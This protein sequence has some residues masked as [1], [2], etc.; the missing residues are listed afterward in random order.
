MGLVITGKPVSPALCGQWRAVPTVAWCGVC[1]QW[2]EVGAI[3]VSCWGRPPES[4]VNLK[5]KCPNVNIALHQLQHVSFDIKSNAVIVNVRLV[6]LKESYNAQYYYH[7]L[8]LTS[9]IPKKIKNRKKYISLLV[10]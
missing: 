10:C 7:I 6:A 5:K 2:S 9:F 8:S 1:F 3:A 4:G